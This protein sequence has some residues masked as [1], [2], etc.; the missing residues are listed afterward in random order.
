MIKR[1]SL[2]AVVATVLVLV[3]GGVYLL[4]PEPAADPAPVLDPADLDAALPT[5]RDLAGT[6]VPERPV[7][8]SLPMPG[9]RPRL[10][11]TGDDLTSQCLTW[12]QRE[13]DWA[14][15]GLAGAGFVGLHTSESTVHA[16]VLAYQDEP[17]AEAALDG[18]F[19]DLRAELGDVPT[20]VRPAGLGDEGTFLGSDGLDVV[21]IRVGTVVVEA[22]VFA[23]GELPEEQSDLYDR[24][25]TVLLSKVDEA[26]R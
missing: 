8:G 15:P 25:T 26:V 1:G 3:A 9:D 22:T 7:Y 23:D 19:S 13:E 16:I 18:L 21:A 2:A 4:W 10:V 14:C 20:E 12:Q 24:W 11:L 17:A 5:E 6:S